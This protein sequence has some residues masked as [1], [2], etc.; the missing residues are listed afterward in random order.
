MITATSETTENTND[1]YLNREQA[2]KLLGISRT[3]LATIVRRYKIEK[4]TLTRRPLYRKA[5][6]VN[7]I[8]QHMSTSKTTKAAS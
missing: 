5:D 4:C 8:E 6:L 1:V 2:M 7:L 3:T